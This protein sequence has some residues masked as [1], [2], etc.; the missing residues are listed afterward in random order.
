MKKLILRR[1][2]NRAL[3]LMA[4]FCPGS[5]TFRPLLH[6]WRG[7][8]I[9]RHVFIGEDV[10]LDNEYPELIEIQDHAQ[11]SI[12]VII[13]A[14]THGPGRVVVGKEAF[15][16]PYSVLFCGAGGVLKIGEGA[17]VGAGSII[18][19]SIPP[20]LYVAPPATRPMARVRVPLPAAKTMKEF[21]SGLHPLQRSESN[22]P[23]QN[24]L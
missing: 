22:V 5:T 21:W 12:R 19:K 15:V 11:I 23:E 7:V 13:I 17:V 20:R 9:G 3:H 24:R 16:G 6:R 2:A 14:H 1:A 4:R 10:Y 8:K 18:S